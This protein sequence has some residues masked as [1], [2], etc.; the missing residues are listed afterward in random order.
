MYAVLIRALYYYCVLLQFLDSAR[1]GELC[2][3]IC[4][5]HL[6][7]FSP[8][9]S[10]YSRFPPNQIPPPTVS[11]SAGTRSPPRRKSKL[12]YQTAAGNYE[13]NSGGPAGSAN[14][15]TSRPSNL[16]QTEWPNFVMTT[17]PTAG[18]Q[19]PGQPLLQ[20]VQSSAGSAKR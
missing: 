11:P 2:T 19:L 6:R 9:M 8:R 7:G 1:K 10:L 5:E 12:L 18:T 20:T 4:W 13:Q 15:T 16:F 14:R 17:S 3:R